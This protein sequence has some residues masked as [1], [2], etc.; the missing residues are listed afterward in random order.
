MEFELYVSS[1]LPNN[2]YDLYL[3]SEKCNFSNMFKDIEWRTIF[4]II[5]LNLEIIGN[6]VIS[7]WSIDQVNDIYNILITVFNNPEIYIEGSDEDEIKYKRHT[8]E[9]LKKD[10]Y[11]LIQ[12]FSDFVQNKCIIKVI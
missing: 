3:N 9:D 4:K 10:I 11:I 2:K 7:Y 5:N 12:Y 8:L 1:T 6:N